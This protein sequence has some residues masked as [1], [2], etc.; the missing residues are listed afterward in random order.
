M[1]IPLLAFA[2][3]F[4]PCKAFAQVEKIFVEVDAD[5]DGLVTKTELEK[6]GRR[7]GWVSLADKDGD[8]AVSIAEAT[9]FFTKAGKKDSTAKASIIVGELPEVSS[10]SEASCRAAAEYSAGKNGY[11]FLVMENGEIVFERYD[12]GWT[13]ET[14]YRLASGT[15]S[16]SGAMV[17]AAVKDDLLTLDEPVSETIT[18]WQSDEKLTSITIRQLLSLTSGILGGSTGSIPSYR[19]AVGAKAE[20]EPGEKFSYGPMPYQIFGELMRRKLLAREDLDFADP[21]AYLEARLFQPIGMTYANWRRDG[22]GMPHLPSGAFLSAREWA[23]FGQLL[24]EKGLWSGGQLLDSDALSECLVGSRAN[25]DYG[26]TFWLIESDGN[27]K[28]ENAYMAAGA[29]KQRLYI[30]PAVG[31]VVVRQGESRKFDDRVLLE[32]LLG[33]PG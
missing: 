24:M 18:E 16:F 26:V 14:A 12:Q 10:V 21:L 3:F 8:A 27:P 29:G 20:F 7:S 5:K 28:L 13:P 2:L 25:P 32:K 4:L 9:A 11:T 6:A 31:L 30:L 33:E 23:K 17:A 15:K 22:N 1:R 19:E